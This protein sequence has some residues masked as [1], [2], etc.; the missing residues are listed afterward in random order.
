LAKK[1]FTMGQVSVGA[2]WFAPKALLQEGWGAILG[3]CWFFFTLF[4]SFFF[5][6]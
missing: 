5:F 1:N 6:F 3:A 4:T 2:G